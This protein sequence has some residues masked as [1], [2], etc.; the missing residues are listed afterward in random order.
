MNIFL[1]N[2][3]CFGDV[4]WEVFWGACLSG[5]L[6]AVRFEDVF[7]TCVYAFDALHSAVLVFYSSMSHILN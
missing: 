4:N 2:E 6:F 1:D 7:C 5:R 3:L